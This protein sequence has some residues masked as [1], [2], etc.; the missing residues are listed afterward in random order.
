ME[1]AQARVAIWKYVYGFTEL[2]VVKCAIEL[3]VPD[4]LEN[5]GGP[6]TLTQLSSALGCSPSAPYRIMRFLTHHRIFEEVKTDEEPSI[7]YIQTA[8][9][10]LLLKNS[11]APLVQLA[12]S[13][14]ILDSWHGLSKL[15]LANGNSAFEVAHG[16]DLWHYAATNPSHNK[17]FKALVAFPSIRGINF[18]LPRV[19]SFAPHFEGVENVQGDFFQSVPNADAALLMW[20][21]RDW[22]DDARVKMLKNCREAIPRDT[23]EVIIVEAV[24]DE[25]EG[26]KYGDVHLALDIIMMICTVK[27][28]ERTSE[29][30]GIF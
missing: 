19:I 14:V 27:G 5:H 24:I 2:A 23:G 20:V 18:D 16:Q 7:A 8:F 26:N 9:S 3:G 1:E 10:R 29:E 22:D 30:W 11:M 6:M 13:P 15:V 12:T 25:V 21:L 4:I 28:K 17:M